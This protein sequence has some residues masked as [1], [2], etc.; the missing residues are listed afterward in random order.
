MGVTPLPSQTL[1][2]KKL[3]ERKKTLYLHGKE[4]KVGK[5]NSRWLF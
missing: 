2:R 5:G 4:W 1:K 3:W